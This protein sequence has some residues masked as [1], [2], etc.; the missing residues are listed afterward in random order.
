M[1]IAEKEAE[2]AKKKL[3]EAIKNEERLSKESA[4]KLEAEKARRVSGSIEAI[5]RLHTLSLSL[6]SLRLPNDV[7]YIKGRALLTL[8]C[9]CMYNLF[10][11]AILR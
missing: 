3:E 5:Y 7:D 11:D 1:E 10:F 9:T 4:E 2:E 6:S 8:W